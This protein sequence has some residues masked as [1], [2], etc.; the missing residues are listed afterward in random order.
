MPDGIKERKALHEVEVAK[1]LTKV[2]KQLVGQEQAAVGLQSY[3]V[4]HHTLN[5]LNT[6]SCVA[7]RKVNLIIW[8][9][10]GKV[11]NFTSWCVGRG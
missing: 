4:C 7:V 1:A 6:K 3:F 8:Q 11:I 9:W 2:S 10:G 5:L